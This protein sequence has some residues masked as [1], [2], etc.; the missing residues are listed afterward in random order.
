ML[1]MGTELVLAE[2]FWL[3]LC[4]GS[5]QEHHVDSEYSKNFPG[6]PTPSFLAVAVLADRG[7]LYSV[8][9]GGWSYGLKDVGGPGIKKML[10]SRGN[11]GTRRVVFGGC[12][13]GLG[14]GVIVYG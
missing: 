12:I 14:R 11:C 4:L 13:V 8:I 7:S 9:L 6:R 3:G 5:G 10:S 2:V 1:N